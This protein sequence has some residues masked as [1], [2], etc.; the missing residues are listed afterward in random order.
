MLKKDWLKRKRNVF[1]VLLGALFFYFLWPQESLFSPCY[2]TVLL[3]RDGELLSA[4]IASDGQWRFPVS[5]QLPEKFEQA[6]L[7]FEDEHFYS[8]PGVNPISLGRAVVQNLK[9]GR[10]VSGASTLTMQLARLSSGHASRS[11]INKLDEMLLA[12]KIEWKYSKK[13]ILNLY[14]SHAPFGGN[15]VGLEAAAWRYYGRR[16]DQL[17]WA[18]AA[19]LAVLPNSP[20]LIYPGKNSPRLLAKRNRLLRKLRD[21]KVLSETDYSLALLEELPKK[22]KLLPQLAM[23]LLNRAKK[24]GDS[25]RRIYSSLDMKLQKKVR[26]WVRQHARRLKA[27]QIHNACALVIDVE[28]GQSLAYVGNVD[29]TRENLHGEHV[30]MIE[31]RRSTGSVL[32]PFLYAACL[33]D[34]TLMPG[35]L[36][37]DT[38]TFFKGFSPKNFDL[39]YDGA[40]AAD[41]ALVRSLNIPFVHLLKKF[42]AEKFHALLKT[43]G[44]TTLDREASHY[45]LSLIL[46]GA[47]V[48][49]WDLTAMY[50]AWGR[51]LVDYF[52]LPEPNR[53][54]QEAFFPNT[55][56]KRKE[57]EDRETAPHA[58][59]SASSVYEALQTMTELTRPAEEGSWDAFSSSQRIAWKTG[60]SYGFRDAWAVGLNRKYVV[61]V[62]VGNAD[63]E[64]RPG[65]TGVQAAAPLMFGIFGELPKSQW[66]EK[67]SSD[68]VR[69]K[70]C[71]R[72]GMKAG[73]LCEA[74]ERE[75]PS[76]LVD[77]PYCSYHKMLHLSADEQFQVSSR[78]CPVSRIKHRPWFVLPKVE[79]WY[80]ARNHSDYRKAPPFAPGCGGDSPLALVYPRRGAKIYVPRE[81]DGTLGEA[82]FEA[83]NRGS[84]K[85]FWHLDEEFLGETEYVHQMALRPAQGK[86]LLRLLDE[87]GNELSQTVEILS[88]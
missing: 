78:C 67:P 55:Y 24:E 33:N 19:L 73:G 85:V 54:Y 51:T 50:A 44:M 64:G 70:V 47:E 17:S 74:E 26:Q 68:M 43:T 6:L 65:L 71:R 34:G 66:F 36:L 9:A 39:K 81:L 30:D 12:L 37:R 31:A 84:G 59:Y 13:E 46:G 23:H 77:A 82:V 61:G 28:T 21:K 42:S 22:P 15:V 58:L 14:A 83:V 16:P 1:A 40:V 41:R 35:Q 2:S 29:Y 4:S 88:D 57:L 10:I 3:S 7:L 48:S 27:N 20:S 32:K 86:H 62:W 80:Y 18:E 60:T 79:A 45:G 38:P 76:S 69:M 53:Y 49:L 11:L 56:R 8:H 5:E 87:A 72:S 25:G 75:V 52:R 63:G